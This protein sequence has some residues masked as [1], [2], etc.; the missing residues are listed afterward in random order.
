[1][2]KINNQTSTLAG[3]VDLNEVG[4]GSDIVNNKAFPQEQ[5]LN[6]LNN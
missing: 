4:G 2:K 3:E 6:L 5:G 1:M